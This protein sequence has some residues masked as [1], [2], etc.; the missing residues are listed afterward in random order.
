PR[1][2][3]LKTAAVAAGAAAGALHM[4]TTHA[5]ANQTAAVVAEAPAAPKKATIYKSVKWGM[6]GG[7]MS[8]LDKF[9][10]LQDLGYDGVELDSPGGVNKKEALEASQQ[11]GLPIHGVVDST[12]W[13]VRLSSKDPAVR[14][15]G[16]GD[17][18]TA[19]KD[20]HYCGGSSVLLVA[21]H[22]NDG[23]QEEVADRS[24]EQIIKALPLASKLGIHILIENVWNQFTYDHGGPG[25]QTADRLCAFIDK[26]NSPWVGSYFD[27]GNHR[28]YGTPSQWAR[29]LGKRI[30][31]CDVK[32][33][34]H[35][36]DKWADIGEGTVDWAELR[37]VLA[38]INFHGWVTAEVGGGDRER[39]KKI[40]QQMDNVLG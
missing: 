17:L 31:K 36:T 32:D 18:L 34:N 6:V 40:K 24:A 35:K 29:T 5:D 1:R 37:G 9:R 22:G 8:V 12:H 28:K 11:T 14:E 20:S 21:G 16:L 25:D 39:L 26:C 2:D 4:T 3:F 19:I 7:N 10:M 23:T 27:I 38:D 13:N 30:V 33:F 15:K